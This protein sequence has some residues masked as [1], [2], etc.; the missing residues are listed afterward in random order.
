MNKNNSKTY[1]RKKNFFKLGLIS[2]FIFPL[3]IEIFAKYVL[4]LGDPPI[5][6]EHRTI[7]YEFAPNQNLRRFHKKIKIN[8]MGMRS[9][10]FSKHLNKKRILVYGDS[11]IW[12]GS[13]TD[14]KDLSTEIL[15]RLLEENNYNFDVGNVSAG[16]WGP[17]NWLAHIKERGIYGAEIVILVISSHDW[18]DN[19]TYQSIKNNVYLPTKKPNF[20]AEELITRYIIPKIKKTFQSKNIPEIK[21]IKIKSKK[22]LDDIANFINVVREKDAEIIVVQ[23]WDRDEFNNG[24]PKEGNLLIKK[25]LN[26]NKVKNIDSIDRFRKCSEDS[27][28]LFVDNIHPFTKLGQKCLGY[29]L[30]EAFQKTK[31][32]NK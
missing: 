12:G 20:A 32:F 19:P 18:V 3:F 17:G 2:V 25:V 27:Q 28:S 31:F 1:L 24:K 29:L 16:S 23:F 8:S 15:K 14:Q 22:G 13:L 11:V 4:G 30:F 26:D 6:I 9:N 21:Q 10:E 7:E 5:S